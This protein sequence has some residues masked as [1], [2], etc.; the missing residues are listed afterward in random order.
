MIS[1]VEGRPVY[2]TF[3]EAGVSRPN[4]KSKITIYKG[5]RLY[6]CP[7]GYV[8]LCNKE[9]CLSKA[10]RNS[11]LCEKHSKEI[12][13]ITYNGYPVTTDMSD[14][15]ILSLVISYRG[16]RLLFQSDKYT[17]LC[18]N[19]GCNNIVENPDLVEGELT[20]S[21]RRYFNQ[22]CNKHKLSKADYVK[23]AGERKI[24]KSR[25]DLCSL[26]IS[27]LKELLGELSEYER[28]VAGRR[29][30]Y[31]GDV[32]YNSHWYGIPVSYTK[33][34]KIDCLHNLPIQQRIILNQEQRYI[35]EK[36]SQSN[37]VVGAGPG[38]GK[39]ATLVDIVNQLN[40][41]NVLVLMYGVNVELQFKRRLK[42]LGSK[43]GTKREISNPKGTYVMTLHKYAYHS[44]KMQI[45][46]RVDGYDEYIEAVINIIPNM[47]E[48]WDYVIIDEAQDLKEIYYRMIKTIPTE[49]II[50]MG[51]ARQQINTGANIYS[52]IMESSD[53]LYKL[54]YNHR[55][56][57]EIVQ[58]LNKFSETNFSPHVH[59]PQMCEKSDPNSLII[60]RGNQS[61]L[62]T[63]YVK[64]FPPGSTFVISPVTYDRY[65]MGQSTN[66]I[67]QLLYNGG[68]VIYP[69]ESGREL[70]P[71]CD[72]ITNSKT[73]KGLE[74]DQV[75]LYGVSNTQVY[76]DYNIPEYEL[77]CLIYVA[78]SRARKRLVIVI[79]D[80]TYHSPNLL[81]SCLYG[82]ISME[83]NYY[84]GENM[85][86]R[87]VSKS[88]AISVTDLAMY[89]F[90]PKL[91][92][93]VE[94]PKV[95]FPREGIEDCSGIYV[96]ACIASKLGLLQSNYDYV[97]S[98]SSSDAM[99][100]LDINT[101]ICKIS[102]L[103]NNMLKD[104]FSDINRSSDKPEYKYVRAMYV[105]KIHRDWTVSQSLRD[106][107]IDISP[108]ANFITDFNKKIHHSSRLNYN[109]IID[110]SDKIGGIIKGVTDFRSESNIFEI[111]H[112]HNNKK[113]HNQTLIYR[114]MASDQSSRAF[115]M[116]TLEGTVNL[117]EP[118]LPNTIDNFNH[119]VRA[120][121]ILR[122]AHLS[123]AGSQYLGMHN[124]V[125]ISV[126]TEFFDG[127][128]YEIGAVAFDTVNCKVLGTYQKSCGCVPFIEISSQDKI[129]PFTRL[130]ALKIVSTPILQKDYDDF[131]TW[132]SNWPHAKFIQWGTGDS[133]LLNLPDSQFIDVSMKFKLY[134]QL[135]STQFAPTKSGYRLSDAVTLLF[136]PNTIWEP[137]RAFEDA[138]LTMGVYY[139]LLVP[140]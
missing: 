91:T 137:H 121:L 21:D 69:S 133:K 111:K 55:S 27:E 104:I 130:T 11:L 92:R 6:E 66:E 131:Y 10:K 134:R 95:I 99:S 3:K 29:E 93:V 35:A 125:I 44:R 28:R 14:K 116:N 132:I 126:D 23:I 20:L 96:E 67:R 16:L 59:I 45:S 114:Y 138:V 87:E 47:D 109:V 43:I 1:T 118:C 136:P 77:K 56:T 98:E 102:A 36:I 135:T 139:A 64:D 7:T 60:V 127:N 15:S 88:L 86:N 70:D 19:Q 84:N 89:D 71:T 38:S 82:Y 75:I 12:V 94:L 30:K 129:S 26:S 2:N 113:H 81:D 105:A 54:S 13:G 73:I 51:D 106:T 31:N 8:L 122:Q 5:Y 103:E 57:Y 117:V 39:T 22:Q 41:L 74:R 4:K 100:Y 76:K 63:Q 123:R 42:A 17:L 34:M 78:L 80:D 40:G 49:C 61:T 65:N 50:Y 124:G 53:S 97:I 140:R 24:P 62:V 72:Y 128:V 46:E 68:R 32:N 18:S 101:Y 9:G 85:N 79:D 115:L 107:I 58:I 25:G 108:Y 83:S 120:I 37:I 90:Y 33:D 110:R 52:S 48:K 119:Y 112:A